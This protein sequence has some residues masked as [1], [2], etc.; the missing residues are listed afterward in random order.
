MVVAI[1]NSN[2]LFLLDLVLIPQYEAHQLQTSKL[3]N[4]KMMTISRD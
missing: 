4:P 3:S 1:A 2:I